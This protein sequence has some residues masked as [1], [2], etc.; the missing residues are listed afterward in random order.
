MRYVVINKEDSSKDVY[1]W[2]KSQHQVPI[3][4]GITRECSHRDFLRAKGIPF[5]KVSSIGMI[6][7]NPKTNQ[8]EV[9]VLSWSNPAPEE[10]SLLVQKELDI[11][12]QK[13]PDLKNEMQ[14]DWNEYQAWKKRSQELLAARQ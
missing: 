2:S 5:E 12:C 1:I 7:C 8:K 6:Y 11:F 13:Y 14:A 4:Q 10:D 3:K 9:S